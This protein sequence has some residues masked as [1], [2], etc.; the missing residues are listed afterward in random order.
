MRSPFHLLSAIRDYAKIASADPAAVRLAFLAIKRHNAMQ[1]L[2][3]LSHLVS[4]VKSL[5]SS[6]VL[7]I[8][9]HLGG[10]LFCWSRVSQPGSLMISLDLQDDPSD[11]RTTV[12]AVEQAVLP[13]TQK[14]TFIRADSHQQSV[15]DQVAIALDGHP[16]D[17]LFIDGDHSYDG[18]RLDFEMYR[19]FVR[20]GGLIAFHDI[21]PNRRAANYGVAKFW[22][23]IKSKYQSREFIDPWMEENTG[24]G[25]GVISV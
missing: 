5:H 9:S 16:V 12:Q 3:E 8:G 18:V 22:Q 24:M 19:G 7:E 11:P 20:K 25:I 10:T 15:R 2:L 23:E 17:F 14:R 6:V 13:K 1:S 4:E 21:I